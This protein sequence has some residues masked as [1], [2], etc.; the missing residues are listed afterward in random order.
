MNNAPD[1]SLSDDYIRIGLAHD[2]RFNISSEFFS[3]ENMC[4][5]SEETSVIESLVLCTKHRWMPILI[6][7]NQSGRSGKLVRNLAT[8]YGQPLHT[9]SLNSAS[10]T[11]ELLGGFEQTGRFEKIGK[12]L[13]KVRNQLQ[14]DFENYFQDQGDVNVIVHIIKT[15]DFCHNYN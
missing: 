13:N 3:Q 14:I 11:S 8:L 10:D 2:K 12:L 1:L 9:I 4:I 6:E 5:D 7:E 15:S